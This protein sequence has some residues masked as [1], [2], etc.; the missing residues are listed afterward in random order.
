M[1]VVQR[2]GDDF[3]TRQ[4]NSVHLN[5]ILMQLSNEFAVEILSAEKE[6]VDNF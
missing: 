6:I 2:V 5:T 1:P 3:S 4:N